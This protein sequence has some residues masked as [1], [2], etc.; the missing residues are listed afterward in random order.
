MTAVS[1]QLT[2]HSSP[3]VTWLG[4]ML[5]RSPDR[6]WACPSCAMTHPT[7]PQESTLRHS[8]CLLS[9]ASVTVTIGSRFRLS[10]GVALKD[11][12]AWCSINAL[13]CSTQLLSCAQHG[14]DDDTGVSAHIRTAAVRS[15]YE[16]ST[17]TTT[18]LCRKMMTEDGSYCIKAGSR[19][20]QGWIKAGS[21]LHARA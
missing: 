4:V 11:S 10:R 3:R 7:H 2:R 9:C 18:I 17:T 13:P 21:R 6:C 15:K 12:V 14:V 5:I 19:L 1:G 16:P 8:Q 20:D